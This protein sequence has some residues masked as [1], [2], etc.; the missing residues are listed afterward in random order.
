MGLPVVVLLILSSFSFSVPQSVS[1]TLVGENSD[2]NQVLDNQ[3]LDNVAGVPWKPA[4]DTR[5][6]GDNAGG[7]P[8]RPTFLS[9]VGDPRYAYKFRDNIHPTPPVPEC[10]MARIVFSEAWLSQNDEDPMPDVAEITFPAAWINEN[11]AGAD[12]PVVVLSVPKVIL[13]AINTSEDPDM[14][15]ISCRM[16]W[17]GSYENIAAM[18]ENKPSVGRSENENPPL[19][20]PSVSTQQSVSYQERIW[21]G[22]DASYDVNRV[23][24]RVDPESYYNA[25]AEF[26]NYHEREIYLN[27]SGDAIEFISQF[28]DTGN[29]YVWVA[30]WDEGLW[31][32]PRD[33]LLID[34][35][36]S[37]QPVETFLTIN[38]GVYT[39]ELRDTS[40]GIQITDHYDDTD[41][42]S[43]HVEWL[44]GS[45]ELHLDQL[46]VFATSTDPIRDDWTY[47]NGQAYRPKITFNWAGQDADE[48][49]VGIDGWWDDSD[50]INTRHTTSANPNF[51]VS[52][53]P[54]SESASPGESVDATVKVTPIDGFS[55]TVSLSASSS[56]SSLIYCYSGTNYNQYFTYSGTNYNKYYIYSGTKYNKYFTY[57]G[58]NYNKWW[59]YK[60]VTPWGTSYGWYDTQQPFNP[61]DSVYFILQRTEFRSEGSAGS[62]NKD[63]NQGSSYTTSYKDGYT[64]WTKTGTGYWNEGTTTAYQDTNVSPSSSYK[65]GYIAWSYTGQTG[66]WNEGSAGSVNQDT[67]QGSSYTTSYKDGYTQWTKTGT[68]YWNEGSAG[69]RYRSTYQGESYWTYDYKDGYTQWDLDGTCDVADYSFSPDSGTPDFTSTLTISTRSFAPA[70]IYTIIITGKG[71]GLIRTC[72]Y[73]LTVT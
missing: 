31:V 22:Q 55:S 6:N 19:P 30:V 38:N 56:P 46:A 29:V 48:M 12:E 14:I 63:T 49:Y 70:G 71:G 8:P 51:S 45:T 33:W 54:E 59:Y 2:N 36:S 68:G 3:V 44:T 40:T 28:T 67:D 21:Y 18:N 64:Q 1:A 25:G 65:D 50:R 10:E 9:S 62:V 35:T 72:I 16:S 41:N 11:R 17:F 32:T 7:L 43:T 73:T 23:E 53:S 60:M 24:G 42:P 39:I 57:S 34:V 15:T 37:L 20:E 61:F 27:R 4:Q 52:V 26:T 47:A 69:T 13:R 58:T 5:D 66:Y